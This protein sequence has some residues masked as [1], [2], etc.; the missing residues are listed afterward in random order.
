MDSS[1]IS[2]AITFGIVSAIFSRALA[3]KKNRSKDKIVERLVF[4]SQNSIIPTY[5]PH[6]SDAKHEEVLEKE[7]LQWRE[8]G[9]AL[10]DN[11]IDA[12]LI[13]G[14]K[15]EM[16]NLIA[17]NPSGV[18]ED[19]GGYSFPFNDKNS[20]LNQIILNPKLIDIAKRV[21]RTDDVLLTQGEAWLKE[22]KT[23]ENNSDSDSK[24]SNQDQRIHMDWPNHN[25][26]HPAR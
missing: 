5:L 26:V 2:A 11:L 22:N 23:S 15:E 25:L 16:L 6:A 3:H 18:N 8:S 10:L 24:Y 7:L 14:A 1:M 12:E 4:T 13:D 17:M 19:F 21:L 20:C 9:F